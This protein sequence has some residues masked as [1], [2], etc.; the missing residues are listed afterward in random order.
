V[1]LKVLVL[2]MASILRMSFCELVVRLCTTGMIP[3]GVGVADGV[4]PEDVLL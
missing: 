2:Q 3:E 4:N 1:Y